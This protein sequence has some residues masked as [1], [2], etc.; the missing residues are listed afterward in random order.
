MEKAATKYSLII[1]VIGPAIERISSLVRAR[2]A[3]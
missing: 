2:L 3:A 1:V